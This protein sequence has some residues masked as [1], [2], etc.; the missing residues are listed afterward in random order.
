MKRAFFVAV[1]TAVSI[2]MTVAGSPLQFPRRINMPAL[3]LPETPPEWIYLYRIGHENPANLLPYLRPEILE[4]EDLPPGWIPTQCRLYAVWLVG[5]L[6]KPDLIDELE[7]IAEAYLL[8][9][10][11]PD[12]RAAHA[13]TLAIERI[14]WRAMGNEA[15]L[16]EMMRWIQMPPPPKGA[17]TEEQLRY[18]E[19]VIAGSRAL[20]WARAREAVPVLI[21]LLRG[22]WVN[23]MSYPFLVRAL[24]RIGDRRAMETLKREVRGWDWRLPAWQVPLEPYEPDPCLVYWQMRTEGM[25]TEQVIAE[26][27]RSM[28]QE[29]GDLQ[30]EEI[31]ERWIGMA[32][33]PQ[34]LR[35]LTH[36]PEGKYVSG[37][38]IVCARLLSKWGVKQAIPALLALLR[39]EGQEESVRDYCAVALGR[40][41][42][43]EAL[44]DLIAAAR[45]D[46]KRLLKYAGIEALG[47]IGDS[48]AEAVLLECLKHREPSVRHIAAEALSTAGTASAIPALELQLQ[49]ETD[50]DTRG[51]IE[52][53]LQALRQK[54]R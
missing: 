50:R 37:C 22:E 1:V 40:L 41:G 54:V 43:K 35:A 39:D 13:L 19:R 44:E 32:A 8:R 18:R 47:L 38:R 14:R 51:Q 29:A 20:G 2:T 12:L 31:L 21:E 5:D 30:Q 7:V 42:A 45:Q 6:A 24:A 17:S 27:I 33:V 10:Q 3:L 16:Q 53:T 34:L 52:L 36:P 49:V 46:E 9:G 28:A 4:R 11:P 48:R 15:Y 26:L 25:N 23:N